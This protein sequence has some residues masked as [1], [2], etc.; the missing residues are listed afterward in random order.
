MI[1]LGMMSG[2]STDGIDAILVRALE[3]AAERRVPHFEIL[4][5]CQLSFTPVQ[6]REFLSCACAWTGARAPPD[7]CIEFQLA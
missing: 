5:A 4:K 3:A 1:V 7:L 2:T 6:R